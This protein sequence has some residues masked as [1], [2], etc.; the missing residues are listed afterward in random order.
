[1]YTP[2]PPTHTL[3]AGMSH[4][5]RSKT[6]DS[7]DT[8]RGGKGAAPRRITEKIAI[9]KKREHQQSAEFE[10]AMQ[11][12]FEVGSLIRLPIVNP[13][14]TRCNKLVSTLVGGPCHHCRPLTPPP[15]HHPL[16]CRLVVRGRK[17]SNLGSEEVLD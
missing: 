11:S 16:T 15:Q 6:V 13:V 12:I 1:M 5:V 17:M 10:Q 14:T 7:A 8:K 3:H 9:I 4:R 2:T